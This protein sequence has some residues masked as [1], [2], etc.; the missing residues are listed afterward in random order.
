MRSLLNVTFAVSIA[1]VLCADKTEAATQR[2][3]IK[4]GGE[5][6]KFYLIE[7]DKALKRVAGVKGVDF[8]TMKDH[9]IVT[10]VH[11]RVKPQDLLSAIRGVKGDGYHC[12]G[13]FDGEPGP[14]QD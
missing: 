10:M 9:V 6:C 3:N 12:T 4:L 13:H 11:G 14:V 5:Y 1:I 2:V 7:V 8:Q